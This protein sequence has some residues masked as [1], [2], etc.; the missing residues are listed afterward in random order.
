[1]TGWG[2]WKLGLWLKLEWLGRAVVG[3]FEHV[4][5]PQAL[6]EVTLLT[7]IIWSPVSMTH[8]SPVT[9]SLASLAILSSI[10]PASLTSSPWSASVVVGE[11]FDLLYS[12]PPAIFSGLG[13]GIALP[14]WEVR[15]SLLYLGGFHFG[16]SFP[17]FLICNWR[18]R[19]RRRGG[20]SG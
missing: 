3:R 17:H 7:L 16:V 2:C 6:P 14:S 9:T 1:M 19:E 12:S 10:D 4:N 11:H 18:C 5:Y 20:K 15:N 8:W 13:G